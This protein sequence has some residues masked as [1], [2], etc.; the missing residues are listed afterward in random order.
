MSVAVKPEPAARRSSGKKDLVFGLGTDLSAP[1]VKEVSE[2][3]V[4]HEANRNQ[5]PVVV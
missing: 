1:H 4:G 2:I 3:N 5:Q